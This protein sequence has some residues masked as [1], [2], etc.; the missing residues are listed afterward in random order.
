MSFA[1]LLLEKVDKVVK[2]ADK[3]FSL[4]VESI[5][6]SLSSSSSS[7]H[8]KFVLLY[9]LTKKCRSCHLGF[10]FG[11]EFFSSGLFSCKISIIKDVV[12]LIEKL[13]IFSA[14][15]KFEIFILN[16]LSI[17]N[18]KQLG[19]Q[20]ATLANPL[21]IHKLPCLIQWFSMFV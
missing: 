9:S 21:E 18:I 8:I 7:R 5:F 6:I 15:V 13:M 14:G 20:L 19:T 11:V 2:E 12:I 17:R 1:S 4:N 3:L 16:L 10:W